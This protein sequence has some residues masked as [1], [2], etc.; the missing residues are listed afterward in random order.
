MSYEKN[1]EGGLDGIDRMPAHDGG[2]TIGM[3]TGHALC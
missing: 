2:T 3:G 1:Q